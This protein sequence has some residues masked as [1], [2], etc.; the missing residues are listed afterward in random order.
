MQGPR[1]WEGKLWGPGLKPAMP[2]THESTR[3]DA[4]DQY[5]IK[6]T[7]SANMAGSDWTQWAT[8][9]GAKRR[10]RMKRQLRG[11]YNQDTLLTSMKLLENKYKILFFK[12]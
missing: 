4:Q 7:R 11:G 5:K 2:C 12:N 9:N 10:E 8:H 6:P 3:S 1:G